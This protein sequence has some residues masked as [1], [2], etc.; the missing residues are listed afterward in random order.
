[1]MCVCGVLCCV[2]VGNQIG[3]VQNVFFSD[4][5]G[6][7]SQSK[8]SFESLCMLFR[9]QSPQNLVWDLGIGLYY[10]SVLK[11]IVLYFA[12]ILFGMRMSPR[13]VPVHSGRQSSLLTLSFPDFSLCSP[14]PRD[15][16]SLPSCQKARVLCRILV[17]R[18]F[19]QFSMTF[20][21]REKW[22]EKGKKKKMNFLYIPGNTRF[23][24]YLARETFFLRFQVSVSCH[25]SA[26]LPMGQV[27][28]KV[29]EGRPKNKQENNNIGEGRLHLYS[30]IYRGPLLSKGI[31]S[32][33]S[34][35]FSFAIFAF[36]AICSL[37]NK[38]GGKREMKQIRLDTSHSV[39]FYLLSQFS[40]YCVI[41]RATCS[42]FL[43]WL[44]KSF[45]LVS[46]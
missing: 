22:Q 33:F 19:L 44:A 13:L 37:R 31:F 41:F 15:T 6:Q 21:L 5:C 20:T 29:K 3:Q 46:L 38:D 36:C 16:F 43:Y 18:T 11:D 23:L 17:S 2:L 39:H 24:D 9:L 45:I 25:C 4:F 35:F 34:C 8:F 26:T 10:R 27:Q 32:D 28:A 7:W 40:C 12:Y 14:F 30:L 1:M 42:C